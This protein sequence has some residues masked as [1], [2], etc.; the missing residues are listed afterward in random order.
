M[1]IGG[2]S[3]VLIN[4]QK[5]EKWFL[6]SLQECDFKECDLEKYMQEPLKRPFKNQIIQKMYGKNITRFHLENL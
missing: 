4:T 5:G 2:V 6:D 1:I 3:L